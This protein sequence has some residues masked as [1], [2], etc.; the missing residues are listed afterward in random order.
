L[1]TIFLK[2]LKN[3]RYLINKNENSFLCNH[4]KYQLKII[5]FANYVDN[6]STKCYTV[7]VEE[8]ST[9]IIKTEGVIE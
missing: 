6:R 2:K 8:R 4:T 1:S 7:D 3:S 5:F 9:K